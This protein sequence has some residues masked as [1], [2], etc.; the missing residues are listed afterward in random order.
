MIKI[1]LFPKRFKNDVYCLNSI[2]HTELHIKLKEQ[3]HT[4]E[5]TQQRGD[6]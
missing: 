6:F 2:Y 5:S 3:N 1:V 4:N